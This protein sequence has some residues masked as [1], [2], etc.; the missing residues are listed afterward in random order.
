MHV[1]S[2]DADQ[3][4]NKAFR[5]GQWLGVSLR[6]SEATFPRRFGDRT[7]TLD[8]SD[9]DTITLGNFKPFQ[10]GQLSPPKPGSTEWRYESC[11]RQPKCLTNEE[12]VPQH[13]P[14]WSHEPL[15]FIHTHPAFIADHNDIFN[16]RLAAYLAAIVVEARFLR[17]LGGTPDPKITPSSIQPE[18]KAEETFHFGR[19]FSHFLAEFTKTRPAGHPASP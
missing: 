4:T 15:A 2:S 12:D 18:C 11:L 7:V 13:I 8:E 17:T 14:A 10:T 1:I 5:L 19:C 3:A 6:W 9:L 16:V